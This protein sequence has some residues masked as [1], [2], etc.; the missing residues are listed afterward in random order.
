MILMYIYSVHEKNA[1]YRN[2]ILLI[3]MKL[4]CLYIY[5]KLFDECCV[6]IKELNTYQAKNIYQNVEIGMVCGHRGC[7]G[8]CEEY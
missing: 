1:G 6:N 5:L 8:L 2:F 3:L 4:K 7:S